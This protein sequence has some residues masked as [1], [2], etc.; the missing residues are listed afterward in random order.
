[1]KA[2]K[3]PKY[4]TPSQAANVAN[5]HCMT[6]YRWCRNKDYNIGKKIGGR[7]RIIPAKLNKFLGK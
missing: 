5:V 1:M 4:L 3:K 6:I 7:W 2:T